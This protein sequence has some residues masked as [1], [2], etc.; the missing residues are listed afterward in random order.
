MNA[1]ISRG[2]HYVAQTNNSLQNQILWKQS[3]WNKELPNARMTEDNC[4]YGWVTQMGKKQV[5]D[6]LD[7]RLG[8]GWGEMCLGKA[9]LLRALD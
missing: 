2:Q 7:Y 6:S 5:R 8:D 3:Q 9:D 1:H 4:Y